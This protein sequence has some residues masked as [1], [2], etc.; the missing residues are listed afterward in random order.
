[1][2]GLEFKFI[3]WLTPKSIIFHNTVLSSILTTSVVWCLLANIYFTFKK[4]V[5]FFHQ[6]KTK[7]NGLRQSKYF[8]IK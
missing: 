3:L 2:G 8:R 4:D 6:N 5:G 7:T 1:M